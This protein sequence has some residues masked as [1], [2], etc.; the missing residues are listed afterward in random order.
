MGVSALGGIKLWLIGE[1]GTTYF[2]AHLSAYADGMVDGL[3]VEAGTLVGYVGNTG[4][5]ISTPPH[6]HFEIHPADGPAINPTAIL[7]TVDD[8]TRAYRSQL[9]ASGQPMPAAGPAV[10]VGP[11]A[12]ATAASP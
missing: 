1:S 3:L 6:L 11:P 2:Y 7:R 12:A 9:I 8:A 10:P 4:N 5:A